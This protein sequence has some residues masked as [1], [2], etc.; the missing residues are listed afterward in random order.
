MKKNITELP[1]DVQAQIWAL[2]AL[3][4]DGIN[5]TDAPGDS[6][7]VRRQ[8]RGLLPAC[9]AADYAETRRG[10]Q[11]LVQGPRS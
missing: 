11:S 1:A 4:D 5:T 7:L 6:R 10:C 9:D 2:E 8:A 3:P